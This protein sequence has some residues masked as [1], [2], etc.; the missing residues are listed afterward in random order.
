M[1]PCTGVEVRDADRGSIVINI[2]MS[3]SSCSEDSGVS[4]RPV[5]VS[6]ADEYMETTC[7]W[8]RPDACSVA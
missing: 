2:D 8:S 3:I 7:L 6:T 1:L 5:N 4:G